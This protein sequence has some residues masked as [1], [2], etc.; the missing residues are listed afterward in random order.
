MNRPQTKANYWRNDTDLVG[1][2]VLVY[3]EYGDEEVALVLAES[4]T[5]NTLLVQ[6][7][8]GE[9]LVGN[10]WEELEDNDPVIERSKINNTH[11]QP[12]GSQRR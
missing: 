11:A 5:S 9:V 2:H 3:T 4:M 7:S 8:D 12:T 1:R 6:A 10:Q